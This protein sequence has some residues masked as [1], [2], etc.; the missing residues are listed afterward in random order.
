M[1]TSKRILL[2][3]VNIFMLPLLIGFS[4]TTAVAQDIDDN[5]RWREMIGLMIPGNVVGA[6]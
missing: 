2:A 5:V 1:N 4:A 3:A 6:A